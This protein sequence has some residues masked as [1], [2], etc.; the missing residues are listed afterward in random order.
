MGKLCSPY[1]LLLQ[2]ALLFALAERG[3]VIMVDMRSC[4]DGYTID[5]RA[6]MDNLRNGKL[7][8]TG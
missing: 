3:E 7:S 6:R 4:H 2:S 8:L 1:Y 5:W